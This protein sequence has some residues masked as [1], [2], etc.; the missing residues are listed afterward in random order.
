MPTPITEAI[1]NFRLALLKRPLL[2]VPLLFALSCSGEIGGGAPNGVDPITGQP[3]GP[4]GTPIGPNGM[5]VGPNGGNPVGPNGVPIGPLVSKPA[6]TTRFVRLNHQQWENTV[7]DLLR[8]PAPL[9][10][11]STFVAEP[12]RSTF[13]TNGSLLSV[14]ADLRED[15]QTASEAVASKVVKDAALFAALVPTTPA[16]PTMRARAFLQAFGTRAFRRP[17]TDDELTRY[18]ALF[19]KAPAVVGGTNAF[20]DGIELMISAML[21]SPAF[22][23]RSELSTTAV[24]G[25][26]PLNDYEVASKLSYALTNTMPD[27]ALFAAAAGGKLKTRAA[28]LEQATRLIALPAG[29]TTVASFHDQLFHMRDLE[30]LKKDERMFPAFATGAAAAIK[31]EALSFIKNVVFDQDK[32]FAELFTA[33]YTFANTRIG[34]MYGLTGQTLPADQYLK[35]NLDPAQ[36]AGLLTQIAFL[37]TYG[38]GDMPNIILRGVHVAKDFL[39]VDIPPPPDAVPPLPAVTPNSTNRQRIEALTKDPPC[40]TCHPPLINPLGFG[41]E[42][43]DGVGRYRTLDNRLPVNAAASYTL[44]GKQ[45]DFNG[46]VAMSKAIAGS[47]QANDCYAQHW[48]EYLYGRDVDMTFD[49]DRELVAGAGVIS[50][51]VPSAKNLIL[52][53]VTTESFVTRLP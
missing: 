10:L 44:D 26:V 51:G 50:K 39:C 23:Y 31:Q 47:A 49:A 21:Q 1:M 42:N 29:S 11:S 7:K 8:L 6:P 19:A 35:V 52:N 33:P 14:S 45:V 41:L 40:S 48:V 9:G 46:P 17:V 4:N 25:R 16:D 36:R 53:L 15:Y 28:V 2:S 24:A 37:S 38:E 22:L 5:P 13:E 32:G 20:A 30:A 27:D 34:Q 43:L 12:L 18:L 3:V